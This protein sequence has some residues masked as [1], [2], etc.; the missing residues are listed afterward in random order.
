[1]EQTMKLPQKIVA[2][3][4]LA[5]IPLSSF[6]APLSNDD[7]FAISAYLGGRYSDDLTDRETTQE[8]DFE[9]SF[10]QAI[11]LSWY[12]E[13]NAEG[14]L[15]YSN[16]QQTIRLGSFSTDLNISYLQFGGRLVFTNRTPFST[17]FGAGIG[18]TFFIPDDSEYDNE[19]AFSGN[20]SVGARYQLNPQWALKTDLRIYGT[21]LDSQSALLCNNNR[22]LIDI[23]GELFLQTELMAGIEY[24]F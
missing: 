6:S 20:M 19:I 11:A 14:E 17:S 7:F 10:S 5:T 12:Y 1:M 24:R 22:C 23:D 21:V 13:D 8:A 18:A 9:H 16:S 4:T 3:L 2:L 15:L